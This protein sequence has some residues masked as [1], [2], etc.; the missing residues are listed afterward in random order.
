MRKDVFMLKAYSKFMD[1]LVLVLKIAIVIMTVVMVGTMFYQVILR[2]FF[3]KANAWSEELARLMCI[4]VV[5]LGAAVAT[6]TYAHLQIDVLLNLIPEKTRHLVTAIIT[7]ASMLF[8]LAMLKYS[9]DLCNSVG[10]ATSAG[11]HMS[12]KYI[13]L[14]LPV[15]FALIALVSV[16]VILKNLHDFFHFNGTKEEGTDV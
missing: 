3:S 2:Y 6:R 1:G 10:T 15:G 4:W 11:L 14:C 16:E 12:K 5:M 8:I 7:F 9:V 13:Y